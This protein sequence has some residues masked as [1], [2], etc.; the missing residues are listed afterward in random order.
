[1][2]LARP[3]AIACPHP[4]FRA[5]SLSAVLTGEAIWFIPMAQANM[6]VT[7]AA[8]RHLSVGESPVTLIAVLGALLAQEPTLKA[9]NQ[10]IRAVIL[11]FFV[12]PITA[13][14]AVVATD[15]RRAISA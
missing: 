10:A 7:N 3:L 15:R 6:F 5:G 2:I 4:V 1:M 14:L 11:F 13:A 8:D 9:L 12:L